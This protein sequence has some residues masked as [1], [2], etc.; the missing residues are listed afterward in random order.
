MLS[1]PSH[2]LV[3]HTELPKQQ[4]AHPITSFLDSSYYASKVIQLDL[5]SLDDLVK[6]FIW[7][8]PKLVCWLCFCL[9]GS[10]R[11]SRLWRSDSESLAARPQWGDLLGVEA[12]PVCQESRHGAGCS[13]LVKRLRIAWTPSKSCACLSC[14]PDSANK[15]CEERPPRL[16]RQ[17]EVVWLH[18]GYGC[19][20]A[21]QQQF[22]REVCPVGMP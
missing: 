15:A 14:Q 7:E 9:D 6:L 21:T 16:A 13:E 5:A 20:S 18:G 19:L 11:S 17:C 4:A 3:C 1:D 10:N 12:L 8:R 22:T 2:F